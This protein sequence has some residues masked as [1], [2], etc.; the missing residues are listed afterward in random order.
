VDLRRA[1]PWARAA[2]VTGLAA[3]ALLVA[4]YA[5]EAGRRRVLPVSLGTANDLVGALSTAL[6]VPVVLALS[7]TRWIRRLGLA[8]TSVLTLAGPALVL[9]LV[10]FGVQMPVALAAFALL[11]AWLLLT[12][13]GLRGRLP[14]PV[15]RLGVLSG[16]GVLA[17]GAVA[18]LGAL[19]PRR[20]QLVAWTVGGVPAALG[21]LAVPVW[22]LRVGRG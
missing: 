3:N 2:G 1:A 4:F 20:A 12:S 13:R 18:A 16:G 10:P 8:A 9:G 7:P 11:A 17:G 21:G 6:M 19:L 15:T 5:L 22:F 14:E